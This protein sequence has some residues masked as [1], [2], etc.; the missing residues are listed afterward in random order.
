MVEDL[1]FGL[2]AD[3][4]FSPHHM[5]ETANLL[6]EVNYKDSNLINQYFEKIHALIKERKTG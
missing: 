6:A 2:R 4:F 3:Q 1:N 5:G